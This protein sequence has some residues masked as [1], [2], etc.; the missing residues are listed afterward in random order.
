MKNPE[1]PSH[2]TL[3]LAITRSLG[4]NEILDVKDGASGASQQGGPCV[5][6]TLAATTTGNDLPIHGDAERN[7]PKWTPGLPYSNTLLFPDFKQPVSS[8]HPPSCM[9][10]LLFLIYLFRLKVLTM[11][12]ELMSS[13]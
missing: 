12:S 11:F 1:W 7:G 8:S 4:T 6:N 13:V 10:A 9:V 2:M 5:H 3:Y